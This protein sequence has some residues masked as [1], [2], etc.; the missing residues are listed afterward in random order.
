[1]LNR[2]IAMVAKSDHRTVRKLTAAEGYLELGLPRLALEELAAIGD[3]GEY[4][5]PVLWMTGE[6]LKANGQF[7][8]AV[9]PLKF[10]AESVAGPMSVRAWQ[11][12][13]DCLEKS[14]RKKRSVQTPAIRN[15]QLSETGQPGRVNL[16]IP[17]FGTLKFAAHNGTI[18]ISVEP[19]KS[20]NDD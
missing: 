15:G 9:A 18:S 20:D 1:M 3:P 13:S 11:S 19:L 2:E 14:G 8:E 6:A 7:D 16:E 5:M 10:V 12:L 17:G 4:Q